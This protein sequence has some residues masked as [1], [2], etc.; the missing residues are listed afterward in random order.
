MSNEPRETIISNDNWEY[1]KRYFN[2]TEKPRE[3]KRKNVQVDALLGKALP[4]AD[5]CE[6]MWRADIGHYLTECKN[7]MEEIYIDHS[8]KYCP[9]CGGEIET[10]KEFSK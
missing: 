4:S 10:V 3:T 9:H 1:V 2:M 6:W 5:V 8:Y 7:N